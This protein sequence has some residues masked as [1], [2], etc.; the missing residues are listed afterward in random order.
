MYREFPIVLALEVPMNRGRVLTALIVV[1]IA[2]LGLSVLRGG[3]M[4]PLMGFATP[5]S[6]MVGTSVPYWGWGH[7][8]GLGGLGTLA[9][10]GAIVVGLALL[11]GGGGR[12]QSTLDVLK[13]R[14]AAGEITREQYKQIRQDLKE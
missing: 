1:V 3:L 9:F 2:V 13:R 5:G 4:P 10:W 11:A 6:L 14:Y 12:R 8:L 7:G